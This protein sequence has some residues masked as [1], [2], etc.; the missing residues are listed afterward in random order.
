MKKIVTSQLFNGVTLD[1]LQYVRQD[2]NR[3]MMSLY[4]NAKDRKYVDVGVDIGK[5]TN[6]LI[7]RMIMNKRCSGN[8]SE[9]KDMRKLFAD[10][11]LFKNVDLQGIRKKLESIHRRYDDLIEA[12]II[13]HEEARNQQEIMG[14]QGKDLLSILLDVAKD[15]NM[16][17]ELTKENIKALILVTILTLN[18][19][20][21]AL[22]IEWALAELIN[23]PDIMK[24]ATEEI[25]SK[26]G[27][28]RLI[29]ELD[30]PN[31][32]YLQSVVKE[33]LRLHV[34]ATLIPRKSTTD[35]IVP[36]Y[37]VPAKTNM[38]VNIWAIGRDPDYWENPLEFRP[39]RFLGHV[40]FTEWN[41]IGIEICRA[42][43]I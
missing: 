2:D 18:I 17:I 20:P 22:T 30:L 37:H 29:E 25:H 1:F 11:W 12:I 23:H 35:C 26:I 16:E 9:A 34:P 28:T 32:P 41:G 3:F 27:K 8:E 39:E 21:T 42:I 13:E 36:G 4:Q 40:R 6:N 33:T 7:S 10:I 24:K 14:S 31:L 15:E 43:G 38:F 19:Y 5:T